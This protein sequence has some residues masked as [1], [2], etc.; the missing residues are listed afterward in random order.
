MIINKGFFKNSK[1][2]IKFLNF[3]LK[4]IN[5]KNDSFLNFYKTKKEFED[6]TPE[7]VAR[8]RRAF[9]RYGYWKLN[10]FG[11]LWE[12][13][14]APVIG[15]F[16][17]SMSSSYFVS[18]LYRISSYFLAFYF[19]KILYI[20]YLLLNQA[21]YVPYNHS[22]DLN[23]STLQGNYIDSPLH[24]ISFTLYNTL[25]LLDF[26]LSVFFIFSIFYHFTSHKFVLKYIAPP[27]QNFIERIAKIEFRWI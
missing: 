17:Q 15:I 21:K 20:E 25:H 11:I 7:Q 19:F 14:A 24:T 8:F 5:L 4:K 2:N 18:I 23:F 10:L 27:I 3:F 6:G 16:I 22:Y 9:C 13:K 12:P 1:L 26:I